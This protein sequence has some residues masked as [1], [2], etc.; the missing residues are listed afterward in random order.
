M[1]IF[2]LA[3]ML[4]VVHKRG[5]EEMAT[6]AVKYMWNS[7]VNK[8]WKSVARIDTVDRCSQAKW[9]SLYTCFHRLAAGSQFEMARQV[10]S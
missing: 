9:C 5:A 8:W 10:K 1:Q 3:R 2:S 6:P 7:K 4:V